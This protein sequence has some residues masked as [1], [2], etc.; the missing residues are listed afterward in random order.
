MTVF[1]A[2]DRVAF[3]AI[4]AAYNLGG[5]SGPDRRLPPTDC[6]HDDRPLSRYAC[7]PITTVAQSYNEIGRIAM[8]LLL[9]KLDDGVTDNASD[10]L[11]ER[12]L[13]NAENLLRH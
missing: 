3:G 11:P 8:E 7:S 4:S 1:C 5:E 9:H 6:R 13:L 2:N 10:R 12:V